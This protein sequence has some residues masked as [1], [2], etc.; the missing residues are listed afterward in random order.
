MALDARLLSI[1]A[2]PVDQGPLWYLADEGLL[3]NPRR[4]TAYRVEDEVPQLLVELG[5]S[6]DDAEHRRLTAKAGAQGLG[7]PSR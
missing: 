3:Y 1:L 2:C 5:V 7:P 4:L 6:V